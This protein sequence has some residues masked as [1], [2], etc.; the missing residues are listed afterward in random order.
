MGKQG[1]MN[2][3]RVSRAIARWGWLLIVTAPLVG[4]CCAQTPGSNA[5]AVPE[6]MRAMAATPRPTLESDGPDHL[7]LR[8]IADPSTGD[9]WLLRRDQSRPAGPGRLV[10]A[11]QGM[12][13]Q[14]AISGGPAQPWSVGDLLVIHTG[15]ALMVEEHT[16]VVDARL[17]AVALEPAAKG[18]EFK[19]RLKIGGKAVRVIAVSPGHA[20]FAPN[21]EVA[22]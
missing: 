18:A 15:D 8:Q 12:N 9:L 2:W 4:A 5:A 19:A 3:K 6:T 13:T 10:L 21:S 7:V 16:A 14:R 20:S 22:P 1:K 17:D 11:R